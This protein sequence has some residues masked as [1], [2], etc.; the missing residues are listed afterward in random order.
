MYIGI[1]SHGA[2]PKIAFSGR[3]LLG[4]VFSR[5]STSL[6]KM[7]FN[8]IRCVLYDSTA[9]PNACSV[10]SDLAGSPLLGPVFIIVP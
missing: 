2:L 6:K 4:P 3:P 5:G 7:N 1:V 9:V 10:I 8:L